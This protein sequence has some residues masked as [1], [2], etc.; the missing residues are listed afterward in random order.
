MN[1]LFSRHMGS[2]EEHVSARTRRFENF[3]FQQ[4]TLRHEYLQRIASGVIQF[5]RSN[6]DRAGVVSSGSKW[7]A[8]I[9]REDRIR[10][11][12]LSSLIF[13]SILSAFFSVF[14]FLRAPR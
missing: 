3:V 13:G 14:S 2:W 4:A 12:R 8:E 1:E 7:R 11:R 5:Q 10:V 6:R 9:K